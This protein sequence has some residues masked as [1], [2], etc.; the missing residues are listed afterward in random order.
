M[1]GYQSSA[2]YDYKWG[3]PI[4]TFDINGQEMRY[5]YDYIGRLTKIIGPNEIASN[6]PYT[7]KMEYYPANY[8]RWSINT[9]HVETSPHPIDTFSY[10]V[11]YH[12]MFKTED[13]Q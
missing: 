8:S 3:K 1:P 13:N 7:L 5:E 2:Q 10:A 6:A 11:T 4:K 12:M 9:P